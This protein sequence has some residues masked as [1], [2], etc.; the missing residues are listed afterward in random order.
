MNK[1]AIIIIA[2]A[3]VVVIAAVVG[4]ILAFGGERVSTEGLE[5][6][7]LTYEYKN[8]NELRKVEG[9]DL[10]ALLDMFDGKKL[11]G[12]EPNCPFSEKVSVKLGDRVFCFACDGCGKVLDSTSGK[13]FNLSDKETKKL[14]ELLGEYGVKFPCI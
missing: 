7:T 3:A 8:T 10:A 6:G 1:K 9:E 2:V 11:S 14:H 13:Y 12:N 5:G 4:L